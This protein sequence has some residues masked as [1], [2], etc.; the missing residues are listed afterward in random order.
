[1]EF[2][3]LNAWSGTRVGQAHMIAGLIALVI[4]PVIL[5]RP[6][7]TLGHRT[8]GYLYVILMAGVNISALTMYDLTGGPNLF[9]FFAALSLVTITP[10]IYFAIRARTTGDATKLIS[11]YHFMTWSYFGLFAAFISQ[12]ATHLGPNPF[13]TEIPIFALIGGGTGLAA[14]LASVLINWNAKRILSRYGAM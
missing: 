9:H 1:M 2:F 3:D 8:L 12:I 13:G 7:G 10:G 4:G 11:H 5:F 14:I 6:K